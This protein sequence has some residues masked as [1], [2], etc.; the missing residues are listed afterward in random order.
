[1]VAK[2]AIAGKQITGSQWIKKVILP[3]DSPD[4]ATGV[5]TMP[6]HT[7]NAAGDSAKKKNKFVK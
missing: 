2:A 6:A 3:I 5:E 1:M 7:P 4:K